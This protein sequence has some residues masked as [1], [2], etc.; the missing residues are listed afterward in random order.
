[1]AEPTKEE[2]KNEVPEEALL[3]ET[4]ARKSGTDAEVLAV[5]PYII[6]DEPE[7]TSPPLQMETKDPPLTLDEPVGAN[8]DPLSI[9]PA[10]DIVPKAKKREIFLESSEQPEAKDTDTENKNLAPEEK[11][12]IPYPGQFTNRR[13][14]ILRSLGTHSIRRVRIPSYTITDGVCLYE[15]EVANK[16]FIWNLWL[17][18]DAFVRL[19]GR[20]QE[21]ATE[22]RSNIGKDD[23][24]FVLPPFPFK[25][26]KIFVDHTNKQFIETRRRLLENFLQKIL[27]HEDFRYFESFITFLLP[28][29]NEVAIPRKDPVPSSHEASSGRLTRK[30][31]KKK[32]RYR[33]GTDM[34]EVSELDEIT[35]VEVRKSQVLKNDHT[36]FHVHVLN[37]NKPK[38]YQQWTSLKRYQDFDKFQLSLKKQIA[39]RYPAC[40]KFL[41]AIPK[42]SS[43]LLRDHLDPT[44]IERRR[45]LLDVWCKNLVKY[46]VFRRHAAVLEFFSAS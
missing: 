37:E 4:V 21:L 3:S 17:R 15:V 2:V 9:E 45:L 43:K 26:P 19:Y 40:L 23:H 39:D 31:R 22:Y 44:F 35:G 13:E 8:D 30:K 38:P 5:Q 36:V 11:E 14:R 29:E 27:E 46:P 28:P 12:A 41:P 20:L 33:F 25:Q 32:S 34:I 1:M 18:F 6:E 24:R 42:K 7:P 16:S 10:P